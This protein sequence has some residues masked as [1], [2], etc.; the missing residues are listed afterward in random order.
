MNNTEKTIKFYN[1][2]ASYFVPKWLAI[3]PAVFQDE[4]LTYIK[5]GGIILD[6]GCGS[7]RDSKVFLERG[8]E[9][10]A[11]D[12]A[13]KMCEMASSYIGRPVFCSTF[14]DY[15]PDRM[16][17]GIWARAA[18]IHLEKTELIKIMKKLA[19]KLNQGGCFYTTFLYGTFT[20]E[21][22][23][24][25]FAD[26]DEESLQT[27]VNAVPELTLQKQVI[28]ASYRPGQETVKWLHAGLVKKS[29]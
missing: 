18:F 9:V 8:Y 4:F 7:G 17:D 6:L 15:E 29:G 11:M 13:P 23:G 12:G 19:M 10:I 25:F 26:Q 20:G 28:S 5:P 2:R 3:N 16:L 27:I 21:R 14:Q 22:N 1:E 24:L